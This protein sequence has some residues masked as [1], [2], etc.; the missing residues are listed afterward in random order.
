MATATTTQTTELTKD[1]A[2]T[3]ALA[4]FRATMM[5]DEVFQ[6]GFGGLDIANREALAAVEAAAQRKKATG[7]SFDATA[8]ANTMLEAA[9]A[10]YA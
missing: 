9:L 4:Q 5:R 3:I 8:I 7:P 1:E 2:V 10:Y 6:S